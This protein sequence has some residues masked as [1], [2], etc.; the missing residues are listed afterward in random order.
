MPNPNE[1][2]MF[3]IGSQIINLE[4]VKRVKWIDTKKE[5]LQIT[6]SAGKNII[7]TGSAAKKFYDHIITTNLEFSLDEEELPVKLIQSLTVTTGMPH[8]Q[9][10]WINNVKWENR[11]Y[12][13]SNIRGENYTTSDMDKRV[14]LFQ[15]L[16][17]RAKDL[18]IR[19]Y[20]GA[21]ALA[22]A[23]SKSNAFNW[24]NQGYMLQLGYANG[25]L[26]P[27][28]YVRQESSYQQST[29]SLDF[30]LQSPG[31]GQFVLLIFTKDANGT[32]VTIPL[33]KI[34]INIT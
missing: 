14:L 28:K 20:G 3:K 6:T 4:Q 23:Q 21:Y 24:E 9:Y 18:N 7:L 12:T 30:L 31:T 10:F 11:S 29:H 25:N 15:L 17:F 13:I 32:M 16:S 2:E 34:K 8:T 26:L 1:K 19:L 5:N 27:F 33:G 22:E